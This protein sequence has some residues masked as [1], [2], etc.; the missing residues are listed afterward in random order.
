MMGQRGDVK[1]LDMEEEKKE[2]QTQQTM[3]S[4]QSFCQPLLDA[5]QTKQQHIDV[6]P[7][8]MRFDAVGIN[9]GGVF[10]LK[11]GKNRVKVGRSGI[12]SGTYTFTAVSPQL[13]DT[14]TYFATLNGTVI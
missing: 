2:T 5:F 9:T 3:S 10:H 11:P 12:V 8:A 14:I 4:K 1:L 13:T 7:T 6:C